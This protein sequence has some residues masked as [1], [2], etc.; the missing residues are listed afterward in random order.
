MDGPDLSLLSSN[1]TFTKTPLGSED[2]S[3]KLRSLNLQI[4]GARLQVAVA[5]P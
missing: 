3:I 4:S 2:P 5:A 1:K